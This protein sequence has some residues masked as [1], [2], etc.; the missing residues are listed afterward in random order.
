MNSRFSIV[1]IAAATLI[2][3][4]ACSS[5]GGSGSTGGGG[6]PPQN[7]VPSISSIAPTS[8]NA[9]GADFTLT[10][11]GGS[12]ISASTVN[13]NG[14]G[15]AT[16][17][18][19]DTQLTAAI[20]AADI[21]TAGTAQITV[22]NASPGGGTSSSLDFT[23]TGA[24][25]TATPGFIYVLTA[26]GITPTPGTISAFS[27]DPNT[28][29]VASVPGSP[30]QGEA[31]QQALTS[32]PSGKFLY[33]ANALSTQA[34]STNSISA[35]TIDPTTGALSPVAGSPF[36]TGTQEDPSSLAV[37]STGKFLYVADPA[38]DSNFPADVNSIAEFSIDTDTG[39]LTPIAQA[40]CL[41]AAGLAGAANAVAADPVAGFLFASEALG[42]V[43][44]Y[45]I[46]SQG[47]LQQV[48]GSP[49]SVSTNITADPRAIAVDP[50][51]KFVYDANG[52]TNDISA[53]SITPGSGTLTSV[54]GSPF[55]P[56][57]NA[58]P[59]SL[60]M[61]PLGRFM[62]VENLGVN[63]I[64]FS[65]DPS[66]GALAMLSGPPLI[67]PVALIPPAIDPSGK[68]LYFVSQNMNGNGNSLSGFAIDA[69]TGAL[70]PLAGSPFAMPAT[71]GSPVV[72][73][74]TRKAE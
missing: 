24:A 55:T 31:G 8:A 5:G 56:G 36:S 15:R 49:F 64:G 59:I 3:A 71:V 30:F 17:E 6:N 39:A 46:D 35:F 62:Y 38:G 50:F 48:T 2:S 57:P 53:F 51:G 9:G 18:V 11:N 60:A 45:S 70:T 67:V 20:T 4:A 66:S 19:S 23:I 27:V 41:D 1:L 40:P 54:P 34:A 33:V 47:M 61:H 28:G 42:T 13:W 58:N 63:I 14:S 44:S 69:S 22:V 52:I 32:D 65:I 7:P 72:M 10:V 74:V 43:C 16:T 21:A 25:A 73:T 68:F 26:V 29:S 37:D 12:F